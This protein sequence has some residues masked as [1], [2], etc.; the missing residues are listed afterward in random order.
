MAKKV[1]NV[2]L[3]QKVLT[4]VGF[5]FIVSIIALAIMEGMN[6]SA[7]KAVNTLYDTT[8][9]DYE[10]YTSTLKSLVTIYSIYDD[11]TYQ[12]AQSNVKISSTLRDRLFTTEHYEGTTYV[13][14][15]TVSITE[16]LYELEPSLDNTRTYLVTLE[17]KN[18]D[19]GKYRQ[20][21]IIAVLNNEMLLDYY[22]L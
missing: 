9:I 14:Q 21:S 19:N 18:N 20:Y 1:K 15:P 3:R 6:R 10:A 7:Q 4:F 2:E 13:K 5:I 17:V 16:I 11:R 12:Q 8:V 22:T